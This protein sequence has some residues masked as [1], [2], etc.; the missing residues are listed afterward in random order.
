MSQEVNDGKPQANEVT[1]ERRVFDDNDRLDA[2][3]F[4]NL[5]GLGSV[6]LCCIWP[7]HL[8]DCFKHFDL[9]LTWSII[10]GIAIALWGLVFHW[11]GFW[12]NLGRAFNHPVA[13]APPGELQVP[14]L[15]MKIIAVVNL[16]WTAALIMM[17]GGIYNSP[18]S[19]YG[20]T[21]IVI[22]LFLL[23]NP[24]LWK[25]VSLGFAGIAVY[26]LMYGFHEYFETSLFL[27]I[28]EGTYSQV[29]KDLRG[30]SLVVSAVSLG[31][32]MLTSLAAKRS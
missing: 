12:W 17:T 28:K 10:Q 7:I 16:P 25:V 31:I 6:W 3:L 22:S 19:S 13:A 1:V 30:A 29:M 9:I 11:S 26:A 27:E 14:A 4:A 18:F 24:V 32:A 2:V 5:F 8:S 20:V 23:E 15:L 21:M